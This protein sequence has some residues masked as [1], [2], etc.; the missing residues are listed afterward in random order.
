[1]VVLPGTGLKGTQTTCERLVNAF[2][3]ARHEVCSGTEIVVTVSIG[4]AVQG[5]GVNFDQAESI[6]QAADKAVY[7]AKYQGRNRYVLHKA[8]SSTQTI[9]KTHKR[10]S[11]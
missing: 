5:E 9:L 7:A 6:V 2:R 4:I 8:R 1:M 10:S 11:S 3:A